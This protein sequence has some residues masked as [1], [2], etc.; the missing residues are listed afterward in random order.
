MSLVLSLGVASCAFLC[1]PLCRLLSRCCLS[2]LK[3][4]LEF[5]FA[6]DLG[7]VFAISLELYII[8]CFSFKLHSRTRYLLRHREMSPSGRRM[9]SKATETSPGAKASTETSPGTMKSKSPSWRDMFKSPADLSPPS[10]AARLEVVP[11]CAKGAPATPP[12]ASPAAPPVAKL[13]DF[14]AHPIA[15]SDKLDDIAVGVVASPKQLAV[16]LVAPPVKQENMASSKAPAPSA[17][18]TPKARVC[19]AKGKGQESNP[20]DP[21]N[22]S[23]LKA[24]VKD[25]LG[26]ADAVVDQSEQ[27]A[28]AAKW[29]KFQRSL[30]EAP[31]NSNSRS[32]KC[33]RHIALQIQ[34]AHP[35]TVKQWFQL[36]ESNGSDW[37]R[38]ELQVKSKTYDHSESH[39]C[40]EWYTEALLLDKFKSQSVVD[41]I[42]KTKREAGLS[43]PN[44]DAPHCEEAIQYQCLAFDQE[45]K[46]KGSSAEKEITL[47]TELEGDATSALYP[48][49]EVPGASSSSNDR[50]DAIGDMKREEK[51]RKAKEAKAAKE[52]FANL[53]SNKAK[54]WGGRLGERPCQD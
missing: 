36:F 8:A 33:P 19:K 2:P 49:F 35:K 7:F 21:C 18:V 30:V 17:K 28:V 11:T 38:V 10:K 1:V 4:P 3:F 34:H 52:A 26:K 9:N 31:S 6:F 14:V 27:K 24:E 47:S 46:K 20:P 32:V 42:M 54:K 37:A 22:D 12:V 44:P 53:P 39:G 43:R 45:H 23:C 16:P 5:V 29:A 50:T 15:S 48:L 13:D 51:E 40:H 41:A 25:V